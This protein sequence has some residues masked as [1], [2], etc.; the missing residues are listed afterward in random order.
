[1]LM[2]IKKNIIHLYDKWRENI[3]RIL[4]IIFYNSVVKHIQNT[5]SIEKYK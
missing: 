3:M 2:Q 4:Y 5:K 1:M